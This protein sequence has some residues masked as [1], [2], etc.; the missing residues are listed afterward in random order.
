VQ[1]EPPAW[2]TRLHQRQ[3]LAHGVATAAHALRS[4][5]HGGA[6]ANPQLGEGEGRS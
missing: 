6:G 5:D 2:A 3:Q 4:A 1:S